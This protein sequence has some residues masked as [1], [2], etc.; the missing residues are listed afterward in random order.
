MIIPFLKAKTRSIIGSN[1]EDKLAGVSNVLNFLDEAGLYPEFHTI[2]AGVNEPECTVDGKK[3]LMFCSNNYLSLSEHPD[4]KKAAKDAID[5]YG[6]GPGGSRVISGNVDVIEKLETAIADLVGAEDCLTFPTGYMANVA[7]FKALMDPMFFDMPAKTSDGVIFSDEYNHGSI[8]DGCRLTKARKVVFKHDDLSDLR[9]KIKEND[10]P[11]KL[12]VTEGVFSTEGEIINIPEYVE[13][14]R[15]THSM[16]MVDDAHGIGILG[17]NGGGVAD[18]FSC[19]DGVDIWMGSM[20]KAFGGT[21]GYLCGKKELIKYLRVACRSSLLSSA[22]PANAA[23]A[24]LEV[25]NILKLSNKDRNDVLARAQRVKSELKKNGFTVL[26]DD[27][28][29]AVPVLLGKETV[30]IEFCNKLFERGIFSAVFRWPAVPEGT[31]RLRI[32]I[33]KSHTEDHVEKLI[34]ACKEVGLELGILSGAK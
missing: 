23:A 11:N 32:T 25:V 13:V 1:K 22:I 15:E 10:L 21:G 17:P 31:S 12:I 33:M 19:A 7:V 5:K 28:F 24:M 30:A 16:L 18:L 34:R 20:D 29:P 4:V 27:S 2:S 14:A 26:G 6:V 9:K 3:Y 8:V